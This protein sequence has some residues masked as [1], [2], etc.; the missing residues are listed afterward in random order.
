ML[1]DAGGTISYV[2][3]INVASLVISKAVKESKSASV[4]LSVILAEIVYEV[5]AGIDILYA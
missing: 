3:L 4:E 2:P 1:Y 5:P